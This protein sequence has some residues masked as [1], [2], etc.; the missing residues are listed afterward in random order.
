MKILIYVGYQGKEYSWDELTEEQKQEF[1]TQL[2]K[3]TATQ[4]GYK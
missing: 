1:R 3:Q 2:N 4:L